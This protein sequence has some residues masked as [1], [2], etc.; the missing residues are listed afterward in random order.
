MRRCVNKGA[1]RSSATDRR[2]ELRRLV[3]GHVWALTRWTDAEHLKEVAAY[4]VVGVSP[5]SVDQLID[6]AGGERDG[7]A[8]ARTDEMMAVTWRPDDI[9]G[10]SAGLQDPSEDV[11]RGQDL[12][13]SIDRCSPQRRIRLTDDRN[14]LLRR[15][16][17]VV[18][19]DRVDHGQPRCGRAIPVV[20]ERVDDLRRRRVLRL[21]E[22]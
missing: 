14:Q 12:Q 21:A 17:S 9:G 2:V 20:G 5:E 15:E 3:S 1:P 6:W 10:V 7:R 22:T 4:G 18:A 13:R 16:W 19:E 11:D 8:T